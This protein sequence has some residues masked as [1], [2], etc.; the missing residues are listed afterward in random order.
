MDDTRDCGVEKPF[1][2]QSSPETQALKEQ[3]ARALAPKSGQSKILRKAR[4][5]M[6]EES[7]RKVRSRARDVDTPINQG[8][9]RRHTDKPGPETST[10]R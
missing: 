1:T 8:Q 2:I 10:H 6:L 5:K 9:R 7:K 4:E 3:Q